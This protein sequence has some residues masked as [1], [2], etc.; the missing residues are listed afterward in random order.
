MQG[1]QRQSP[2]WDW[3]AGLKFGIEKNGKSASAKFLKMQAVYSKKSQKIH[4][5]VLLKEVTEYL[6]PLP[7]QKFV[8]ATL[9]TGGHALELV[10]LGASV[11]GIDLDPGMIAIAESRLKSAKKG[12]F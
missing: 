7:G 5:T 9:G 3:G 11:L 10:N 12:T 4:E 1:S 8:D 6:S 2:F